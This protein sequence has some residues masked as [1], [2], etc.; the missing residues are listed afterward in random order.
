MLVNCTNTRRNLVREDNS[1]GL[2]E[3]ERIQVKSYVISNLLNT[4]MSLTFL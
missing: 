4:V 3:E 1:C 2:L